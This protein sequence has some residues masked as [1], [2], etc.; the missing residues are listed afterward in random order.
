MHLDLLNLSLEYLT[1]T[2]LPMHTSWVGSNRI[3]TRLR[4]TMRFLRPLLLFLIRL[5]MLIFSQVVNAPHKAAL[6]HQLI[7]SAASYEAANAYERH[8]AANG[9]PASHA[10]AKELL[11]SCAGSFIDQLVESKGVCFPPTLSCCPTTYP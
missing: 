11:S 3:A 4:P 10:E 6:P 9:K 5:L 7:S 8:C 1:H 2:P